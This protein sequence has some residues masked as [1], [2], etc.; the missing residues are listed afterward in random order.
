M[1]ISVSS[2][3]LWQARA[4]AE[5]WLLQSP[6]QPGT[7]LGLLGLGSSIVPNNEAVIGSPCPLGL[8]HR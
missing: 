8:A 7:R 3:C 4:A 2:C 5:G 6:C 1:L